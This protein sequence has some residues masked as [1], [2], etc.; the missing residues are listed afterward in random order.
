M[1]PNLR[2]SL[3]FPA[4]LL[5]IGVGLS[6]EPTQQNVKWKKNWGP[7]VPHKTFPAK[8][9]MCHVPQRWDIL[10]KKLSFDHEKET[11]TPLKGPHRVAHCV[12]CHNDQ[13]PVGS[14]AARGCGG[15]HVDPHRGQLG[16]GCADCHDDRDFVWRPKG[17]LADHARTRFPLAGIHLAMACETCHGRA[18]VGVYTG[19]TPECYGCHADRYAA[20]PGH[21]TAG[22]SRQCELCHR[23]TS[24]S[25][26]GTHARLPTT[27]DCYACHADDYTRGPGHTANNFPHQ[28]GLCH[29][30]RSWEGAIVPHN[31]GSACYSCHASDYGGA[32]NHVTRGYSHQC[33]QCHT[34]FVSF[35]HRTMNHAGLTDCYS[36]HSTDYGGATNHS[37]QSYPRDCSTSCHTTTTW[38]RGGFSHVPLTENGVSAPNSGPNHY[39]FG[40]TFT[41]NKCHST[42]LTTVHSCRNCHSSWPPD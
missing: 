8:C 13:G 20:A 15:C 36:C 40:G 4:M 34:D 11:G 2:W 16:D 6:A 9:E 38:S 19:L 1:L 25:D 39:N 29:T 14:Y 18:A 30:P 33:D 10:P 5:L 28:C 22:I 27:T 37:A 12:R 24:W 31:A 41:C 23:P 35:S 42:Y 7:V 3:L 21:G 17:V 32:P 26:P